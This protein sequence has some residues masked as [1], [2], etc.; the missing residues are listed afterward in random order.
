[1]VTPSRVMARVLIA[2]MTMP[3]SFVILAISRSTKKPFSA[4]L[5]TVQVFFRR[6]QINVDHDFPVFIAAG[7]LRLPQRLS[8]TFQGCHAR[9][10]GFRHRHISRC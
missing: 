10:G 2:L 5:L 4:S 1:M 3:K 9:V 8:P 7:D 6:G